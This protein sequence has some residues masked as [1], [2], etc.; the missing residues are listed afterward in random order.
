[1]DKGYYAKVARRRQHGAVLSQSTIKMDKGY[2]SV[3]FSYW[4]RNE[5]ESQSTI[6]MDKGYYVSGA[7]SPNQKLHVAIHNKNGQGLLLK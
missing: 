7:K 6:K 5:G 1:M 2:Y 3:P 4:F